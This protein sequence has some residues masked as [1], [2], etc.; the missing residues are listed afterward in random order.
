L[1]AEAFKNIPYMFVTLST[2]QPPIGWLNAEAPQNILHIVVT[3]EVSHAPMS[4][5]NSDLP[6]KSSLMSVT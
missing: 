1:N 3:P 6:W 2:R 5:L 4:S